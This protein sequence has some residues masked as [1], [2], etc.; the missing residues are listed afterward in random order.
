ME[1]CCGFRPWLH[2]R[3]IPG[4]LKKYSTVDPTPDCMYHNLCVWKLE[5]VGEI[6]KKDRDETHKGNFMHTEGLWEQ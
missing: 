4:S 1:E 3:I 5:S 2:T 6:D